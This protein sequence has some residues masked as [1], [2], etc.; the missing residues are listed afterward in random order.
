MSFMETCSVR[1]D[2]DSA[3]LDQSD[4]HQDWSLFRRDS[5]EERKKAFSL[6]GNMAI[7]LNRTKSSATF[8]VA[9]T[10]GDSETAFHR[11]DGY[12]HAREEGGREKGTFD[13]KF[14][15]FGIDLVHASC[16]SVL[17][18]LRKMR[19][20]HDVRARC[21]TPKWTQFINMRTRN[22]FES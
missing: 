2:T 8:K 7:A 12:T 20:S 22:S 16:Q 9:C 5:N 14:A 6:L 4:F 21:W 13:T 18:W 19:C 15:F 3:A 17:M 11:K 10:G 1:D